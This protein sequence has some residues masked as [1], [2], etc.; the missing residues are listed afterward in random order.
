MT[1]TYRPHPPVPRRARP[2]RRRRRARWAAGRHRRR[3][4]RHRVASS[5]AAM[6]GAVYEDDIAGDA[7]AITDRLSPSMAPQILL[8]HTATMVSALLMVV[9]AAGLHRQLRRGGSART[10]CFPPSR[11]AA[12]CWSSAALLHR[13]RASPPSS[14]SASDPGP[15]GARDGRASSDTGSAPSRG[16]GA[17]AGLTAA[18]GRGRRAAARRLRPLDRLDQ[19][20]PR[21]PGPA[22]RGQPAAVHGRHGRPALADRRRVGPPAARGT[23]GA[24]GPVMTPC[25]RR[26]P[27]R[28]SRPTSPSGARPAAGGAGPSP[29]TPQRRGPAAGRAGQGLPSAGQAIREPACGGRLRP[30]RHGQPA[31]QLVPPDVAD[32]RAGHRR[33]ARAADAAGSAV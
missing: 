30:P 9:F 20:R 26:R 15:A 5:P 27:G 4:G 16:C 24:E 21:R 18:R 3:R 32:P 33:G 1:T 22:V 23:A 29:A 13:V 12:C 31:R 8:F 25:P 28:T 17:R 7:V 6:T 19:R 2:P 14:C 10:A 11:P